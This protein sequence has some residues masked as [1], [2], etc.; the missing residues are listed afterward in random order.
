V[1]RAHALQ[2]EAREHDGRSRRFNWEAFQAHAKLEKF[3]AE[4]VSVVIC[5]DA[6]DLTVW[7]VTTPFLY[8]HL[9]SNP[10]LDVL[11]CG[12]RTRAVRLDVYATHADSYT[13]AMAK[14]INGVPINRAQHA[15]GE[16]LHVR[17]LQVH[18]QNE[19]KNTHI[20]SC[21]ERRFGD[22]L[23]P[24]PPLPRGSVPN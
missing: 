13:L 16:I 6:G 21:F 23:P 9:P 7:T 1:K 17:S 22:T 11:F 10:L 15:A 5:H 20:S 14:D 2:K 18:L 4:I 24:L 3:L 12:I 19:L 8:K